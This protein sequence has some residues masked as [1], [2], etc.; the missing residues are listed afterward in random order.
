MATPG[1]SAM[2]PCTADE[3]RMLSALR[4]VRARVGE[5]EDALRLRQTRV[6]AAELARAA[7]ERDRD[8]ATRAVEA[9]ERRLDAASREREALEARVAE[10]AER[11]ERLGADVLAL[12]TTLRVERESARSTR[13]AREAAL[14]AMEARA[15]DQRRRAFESA[16]TREIVRRW[17]ED[18]D[19]AADARERA[20]VAARLRRDA[21]TRRRDA[22]A[23]ASARD[24]TGAPIVPSFAEAVAECIQEEEREVRRLES[25]VGCE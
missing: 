23:R 13:S 3:T 15:E 20:A 25:I 2:T 12:E 1:D 18:R 10:D 21:E 22:A 8:D 7:A 14:G 5:H 6:H 9:L 16:E 11:A 24:A 17:R 19:A 4:E